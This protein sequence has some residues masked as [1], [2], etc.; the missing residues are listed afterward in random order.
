MRR[1]VL[2]TVFALTLVMSACRGGDAPASPAAT[3]HVDLPRS[4]RFAPAQISVPLGETVTW[5]NS[6]EFT[7]TVRM[8]D[9]GGQ[10]MKMA[11]G[12]SVNFTFTLAGTHRYECSLHP[13]NMKG[14][15]TV[16]PVGS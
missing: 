14:S 9:D 3:S 8:L 1:A 7:H 12:E 11:P 2:L 5:T 15:V 6:D 16:T 4:Y 13:Q 10:V